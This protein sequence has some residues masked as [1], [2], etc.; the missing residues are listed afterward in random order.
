MIANI[1]KHRKS[2]K[3]ILL[4]PERPD[5]LKEETLADIFRKS[6]NEH[7]HET[8]LIFL[9]KSI[10]YNEL[11]IWSDNIA[12]FLAEKNIDKGQCVGV[13]LPRGLE[14][15]ATILGIIKAG[16]A[17]V[18]MDYEMPAERAG[19]ILS[20]VNAIGCFTDKKFNTACSLFSP[21]PQNSIAPVKKLFKGPDQDSW[22]YVLYTSGTTGKPKGIPIRHR[23]ICN[24]IRAEQNSFCITKNDR[25]YQGFSV[26]FDMWCEETWITYLAGATLWIADTVTAKSIDELADTLETAKITVLHAVP[27]LLAAM[28]KDV[29]S[30]R[31]V[32]AGGEACSSQ[33]LKKWASINRK[34]FNSYGPTETTVTASMALLKPGDP[35]TLGT[36]LP[37]YSIAVV[38][39]QLEP[40]AV[41]IAGELLISG[42]GVSEGYVKRPEL[43]REKFLKKP[44]SLTEM[45]GE[46]IYRTGDEVVINK[47]GNIEFKGRIDDQIKLHGYR[48]EPAE[49]ESELNKVHGIKAS[50]VTVKN[51]NASQ[52]ELVGYILGEKSYLLN[53]SEIR[54][55]L[56]KVLPSYMVPSYFVVLEELPR[57]P[58]GKINRKAL[59]E[60]DFSVS[61]PGKYYD[62]INPDSAIAEKV[63][64]IVRKH[65]PNRNYSPDYDFFDD[66]GGHSLLAAIFVS[67]IRN[68]AGIKTASLK[69]VYL[70]R[71]LNKLI[72]HW[73]E[74]S[75]IVTD[76]KEPFN[77][78]GK[79]SYY[80]C[81]IFQTISLFIIYGLFAMQLFVPF[82]AYTYIHNKAADHLLGIITAFVIY[83][84]IIPLFYLVGVGTKWLVIGRIRA[85]DYPL[86]GSYY[87]RW[88]LVKNVQKLVTIQFLNDTPIY[89]VYLRMLGVKIG[90][91]AQLSNFS[92]GAEDLVTIGNDVSISSNVILDNA[93]IENGLLKIRTIEIG[94]HGYI[95]N[96]AIMGPGTKLGEWAELNDLSYLQEGKVINDREIWKG[97]PAKCSGRHSDDDLLEPMDVSKVRKIAYSIMFG[98]TAF[99]LPVMYLIPLLPTII[100]LNEQQY[101]DT[102]GLNLLILI[103]LMAFSYILIFILQTIILTRLLHIKI[104]PGTFPLYSMKYFRKWISNQCMG[105]SLEIVHSIYATIFISAIFRAFGARIGKNSEISTARGITHKM[106]EIGKEGFI[107]DAATLG[108]MDIRGLRFT[109]K[110]TIIEDK[111]FVGNGSV[112]PQGYN[113]HS[114][115]LIGVLSTPPLPGQMESSTFRDWFG[116]PPIAMPRRQESKS[117]PENIT[118]N[119]GWKRKLSRAVVEFI[120][121]LLPQAILIFLSVVYIS[122]CH[123]LVTTEPLWKVLLL[124]PSYYIV[125]IGVPCFLI[126]LLLK[127]IFIGRYFSEQKPMWSLKV[128]RSEAVTATYESVA[129]PFLLEYLEG[130][131]WLPLVLRMLGVKIGKRTCLNTTDFTE[132]D[133]VS[134]GDDTTLNQDC[135]PQ[136]HL[137]EDR[138]MKMGHVIIGSR[139]TI[140]KG[141]IVLYDSR[142]GNDVNIE[143][144]SLVMKGEYLSDNTQWG[145]S[146]VKPLFRRTRVG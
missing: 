136:T 57:L 116:S 122:Y 135:G 38:D 113:L 108:D 77:T 1:A 52:Q 82:I 43:N 15:H 118:T 110:R 41:G 3:S 69:D 74:E 56:T 124:F 16:A 138:I 79:F 123:D 91:N 78:A 119:P 61:D 115:M 132:F 31:L 23:Q 76:K 35:I 90:E 30:V 99:L 47:S 17:Y 54:S 89:P 51:M 92:I 71:P 29:N 58:S 85:G 107:A 129:V 144:L 131:F 46:K 60:P 13:Y 27:S 130:T 11:D 94:D 36:P 55:T 24:L 72:K 20:E 21:I 50:A 102:I 37:N 112:I 75:E 127:W 86:W 80:L 28:E 63:G 139:C 143:S 125:I 39:E 140:G 70:N 83:C 137:F 64:I 6:A 101:S 104:E 19:T 121:I 114:N 88:W 134:I 93:Y 120:R 68:I 26:S 42:V 44:L 81:G 133:L 109:L 103:P 59:P 98:I 97:S 12:Q 87:F 146:P 128:W 117:F 49:V 2:T 73:E 4:G 65:F 8:A 34:F 18:P 111:S 45:Y 53:D 9:N 126:T 5:L 96:N 40:V 141:S 7:S 106:L 32:N 95:G 67:D 48:I 142:T 22:A 100:V 62:T 14:L 105:M 66:L 25:V 145:G 10:T 84:L 33:V